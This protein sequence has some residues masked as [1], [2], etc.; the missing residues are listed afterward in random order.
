MLSSPGH[1]GMVV[2][3]LPNRMAD[4]ELQWLPLTSITAQEKAKFKTQSSVSTQCTLLSH[5]GHSKKKKM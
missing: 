1:H 3:S 5:H 4:W 2:I